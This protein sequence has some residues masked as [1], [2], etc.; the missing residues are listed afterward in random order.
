MLENSIFKTTWQ[1]YKEM[2]L[3]VARLCTRGLCHSISIIIYI[4]VSVHKTRKT[5][6]LN[7]HVTANMNLNKT[8]VIT[9][10]DNT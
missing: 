8:T 1:L 9:K 7:Y 4:D 6:H 3:H 2:E 10:T 5:L